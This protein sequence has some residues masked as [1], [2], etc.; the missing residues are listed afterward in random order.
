MADKTASVFVIRSFYGPRAVQAVLPGGRYQGDDHCTQTALT[1]DV[2]HT[3]II[4]Q[5]LYCR[6]ALISVRE[7]PSHCVEDHCSRPAV[8]TL[9]GACL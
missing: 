7:V 2:F 8:L 9:N 6:T 1:R 4:V 3:D 5:S